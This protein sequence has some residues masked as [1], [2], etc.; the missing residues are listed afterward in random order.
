[1]SEQ[2]LMSSAADSEVSPLLTIGELRSRSAN[3]SPSTGRKISSGNFEM[4]L[5]NHERIE[6]AIRRLSLAP[7]DCLDLGSQSNSPAGSPQCSPAAVRKAS[8]RSPTTSRRSPIAPR[9]SPTTARRS[10]GKLEAVEKPV[11]LP[12]GLRRYASSAAAIHSRAASQA[13]PSRP[14]Q[15]SVRSS[16]CQVFIEIQFQYSTFELC[17]EVICSGC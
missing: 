10:P 3:S 11:K 9:R 7:D 6:A 15:C 13:K 12:L 17:L 8:G 5:L 4:P 16:W 14:G 1:M 2:P